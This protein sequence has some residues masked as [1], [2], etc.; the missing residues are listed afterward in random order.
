MTN[1]RCNCLSS[2]LLLSRKIAHNEYRCRTGRAEKIADSEYHCQTG[3][4]HEAKSSRIRRHHPLPLAFPQAF[5]SIDRRGVSASAGQRTLHLGHLLP[6]PILLLK[7]PTLKNN[8]G[9]S[10]NDDEQW[11]QSASDAND[12]SDDI[13][14]CPVFVDDNKDR[15]RGMPL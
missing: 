8:C 2:D 10:A 7:M 1:H 3:C 15:R 12:D 4:A 5:N 11:V 14:D 6:R 13:L 9:D